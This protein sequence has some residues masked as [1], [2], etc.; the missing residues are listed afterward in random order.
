L[1]VISTLLWVDVFNLVQ[2][3]IVVFVILETMFVHYLMRYSSDKL[4]EVAYHVDYVSRVLFFVVYAV[5]TVLTMQIGWETPRDA[6]SVPAHA[7]TRPTCLNIVSSRCTSA[8]RHVCP[9]LAQRW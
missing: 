6:N 5:V 9:V 7:R 3:S 8:K 2:L 4:Q 1:G